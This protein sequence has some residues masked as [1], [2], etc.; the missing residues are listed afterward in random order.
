MTNARALRLQLLRAGYL[1]LVPLFGK[2]P[3]QLGKN[4]AKKGLAGWQKIEIVTPEMLD[5]WDKTWPDAQNTGVLTRTMPTLDVDILDEAAAKACQQFVRERYEDAG[6][7]LVRIGQ[8]PKRAIPF[9]TEEPFKKIVVN[10]IAPD[11]SEG[12]KIEF[13]ADGEQVVVAGVHPQTQQSYS[14]SNGG[15]EQV[16][17]EDL[18]YIREEEARALV[19][20]M[21]DAILVQHFGYKR[22]AGRPKDK[23]NGA[24]PHEGGGGGDRDWQTLM[25]NI[26]TGRELHD[27]ITILAAKMIACGTNSGAVI[28]QLRALMEASTATKDERWR[29]RVSEIPAAVDSAVAKYSKS[30][31]SSSE[32]AAEPPAAEPPPAAEAKLSPRLRATHNVFRKWLDK[33]YDIDMLDAVLAAAASEKLGGDP[34]WLLSSPVPAMPRPKPCRRCRVPALPSPARSHPRAHCYRPPRA[35]RKAKGQPAASSASSA[36]TEFSSSRM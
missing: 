10:L 23:Q 24:Q 9:R 31:R 1:A 17:Y 6:D 26:L 25:Q 20:E 27:S 30:A 7:V 18:P 22:V 4:N 5:M 29:A 35:N 11:G 28:N 19:E 2:A 21:V 36:T 32:P 16:K 12:Q 14:W 15:L 13:L 34:L 8:P 3:P 33:E